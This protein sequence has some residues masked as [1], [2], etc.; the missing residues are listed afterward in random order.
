MLKVQVG[1]IMQTLQILN[2]AHGEMKETLAALENEVA[3][4][5]ARWSGEAQSE[6]AAAQRDWAA[7]MDNLHGILAQAR[8]AL[9]AATIA[10]EQTERA[11]EQGWQV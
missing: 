7:R 3:G 6:Y 2:S 4:L 10:F 8:G 1:A 11:V 5:S 9:D